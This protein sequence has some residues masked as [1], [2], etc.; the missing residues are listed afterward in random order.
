MYWPEVHDLAVFYQSKLGK[1]ACSSITRHIKNIWPEK[2][3]QGITLGIGYALPYLPL[4]AANKKLVAAIMPPAQGA[5]NWPNNGK[6]LSL[7]SK[8]TCLPF[9]DEEASK[10]IVCHALEHTEQPK[11]MLREI[12]RILSPQGRVLIIVPN[13]LGLWA[14]AEHTPFGFGH[15]FS[16][17]QLNNLSSEENFSGLKITGALFMP[18]VKSKS[19]MKLAGSL[20]KISSLLP[21][22][23][24]GILILE[25]QK[26]LPAL[27]KSKQEY[28]KSEPAYGTAVIN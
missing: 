3:R 18:P 10:I 27:I 20:T 1:A 17:L 8:E 4:F 28:K 2:Q 24:S 6:N 7:M 15:P 12:W 19:L 21:T 13:R 5:L 9:A 22:A 14:R 16:P 25:A 11:L 23:L 26:K